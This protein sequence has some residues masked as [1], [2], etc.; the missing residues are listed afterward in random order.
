M[1]T[2]DLRNHVAVVTGASSGIGRATAL[3]LARNGASVVAAAHN[4]R[5][6]DTLAAEARDLAG[7]IVPQPT[8]VADPEATWAL[9][10]TATH[11]FGRID[12]W[13][14]AAAVAM[15]A[16]VEDTGASRPLA[17]AQARTQRTV[18]VGPST[19]TFQPSTTRRPTTS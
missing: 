16:S 14:N 15:Y 8:D 5:A 12:S 6:L 18:M 3:M 13:I 1:A 10:A 19:R 11:R 9:A 7:D 4:A 17:P 2:D